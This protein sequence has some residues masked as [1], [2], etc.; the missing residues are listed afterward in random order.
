M[1]EIR[2]EKS[3]D[4]CP[5]CSR[6][7]AS[8]SAGS[9]T[10]WVASCVCLQPAD[11]E[12]D[13]VI[14]LDICT[15]CGKRIGAGRKG[16]FTQF[17]FR[18][19]LCACAVPSPAL[20]PK[21]SP[22][23][24]PDGP[25]P[26]LVP[27]P[28]DSDTPQDEECLDLSAEDF[29]VDRYRPLRRLG[30]GGEGSV[31]LCRD[32]LLNKLV[33]VKTLNHMEDQDQLL[34]FHE[35]ARV[36]SHL[37]HPDII[38]ILDFGV[39]ESG[40]PYMVLEHFPSVTLADLIEAEGP[41]PFEEACRIFERL[42]AALA[43]SHAQGMYHRDVKP[44]NI[45]VSHPGSEEEEVR[46]IDF[47]F[48]ARVRQ[49]DT[50]EI[51]GRSLTGTPAY[52]APELVDGA[53]YDSRCDVYSFGCSL[54]ETLTGRAPFVGENAFDVIMKH[55]KEEPPYDLLEEAQ[56]PDRLLAVIS[57]CLARDPDRRIQDGSAVREALSTVMGAL[58]NPP[59]EESSLP[60]G[61]LRPSL[62]L[63]LAFLVLP[64]ATAAF[65]FFRVSPQTRKTSNP[66]VSR[67]A[68]GA[69]N[70]NKSFR[71]LP[72]YVNQRGVGAY[73][74]GG[75]IDHDAFEKLSK[76]R[77][78]TM[79]DFYFDSIIDW[80]SLPLLR[81][82]PLKTLSLGDTNIR[83][84]DLI[85]VAQ[86]DNISEL[87]LDSTEISSEGLVYIKD[88]KLKLLSIQETAVSGAGLE[89]ISDMKGLETL[90]LQNMVNLKE[91]DLA[92]LNRM[93]GLRILDLSCND[94]GPADLR[95]AAH[96]PITQLSLNQS[97]ITDDELSELAAS[98]T[99]TGIEL[100]ENR[101]L[102]DAGIAQLRSIKSLTY[103]RTLNCPLIKKN[104][105]LIAGKKVPIL[106]AAGGPGG[107]YANKPVKG[108]AFD[109]AA[110]LAAE[111]KDPEKERRDP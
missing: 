10:Q 58:P 25:A 31:I 49:G 72:F 107:I 99:L 15:V 79:L 56:I 40:V 71:L 77:D 28:A 111:K 75:T 12:D 36:V 87:A 69:K 32:L 97:G 102:T 26:E 98:R 37:L 29:P 88:M 90:D 82:A 24:S 67:K 70:D 11:L 22:E 44:S 109:L 61:G 92:V 35:E 52:M 46:L 103:V 101:S 81:T 105:I 95:L 18:S 62:V 83:D 4:I 80:S 51:R 45:L 41:R 91:G 110:D 20:S 64:L 86:L 66:P 13:Q 6:P 55:V 89:I 42:A 43:H 23:L 5:V 65:Y 108:A 14:D 84:H 60:S 76:I 94:I 21:L 38:R 30:K 50:T 47:S 9:I 68:R 53:D 3:S 85:Y 93:T 54:F 96:L 27:S 48:P 74:A 7:R 34:A 59:A 63:I 57:G 33:A 104:H 106:K 16:S 100:D 73:R 39:T 8:Q 17:I 1:D 2:Q 19:Q 78:L